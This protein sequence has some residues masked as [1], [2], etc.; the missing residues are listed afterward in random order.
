MISAPR[1][2]LC[3]F[4][5]GGIVWGPT[6]PLFSRRIEVAANSTMLRRVT[7]GSI[8]PEVL[9]SVSGSRTVPWV[10][11]R[12]LNVLVPQVYAWIA[13]VSWPW[14]RRVGSNPWRMPEHSGGDGTG[15]AGSDSTRATVYN[16]AG[17]GVRKMEAVRWLAA[18]FTLIVLF[19]GI[20]LYGKNSKTIATLV[21][22]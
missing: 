19:A 11:H 7:V 2:G 14:L 9:E 6:P 1:R 17:V 20:Y 3:L 8:L 13:R 22:P 21:S 18:L 10:P 12:M 15:M 5:L 16:K 4:I